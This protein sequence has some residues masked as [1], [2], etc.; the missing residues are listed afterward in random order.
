MIKVYILDTE[1]TGIGKTD[2]VI[3]V[4]YNKLSSLE[5]E[6]DIF[7]SSS[8]ANYKEYFLQD[9]VTERFFPS[10]PINEFAFN[11]HGIRRAEL[12]GERHS[13][14][15]DIPEVD[16]LIGQNIPFDVKML[17]QSNSAIKDRLSTIKLIDAI[18]LARAL[19]KHQSLGLEAFNLDYLVKTFFPED[20]ELLFSKYHSSSLDIL[21]TMVVLFKLITP[22]ENVRTWE[23]LSKLQ[24]TLK[25]V[26]KK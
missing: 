3:E 1:T 4:S 12:A 5:E 26:K 17:G 22:L 18:P 2:D 25:G 24:T 6:L 21:R 14:F 16:Y 8:I 19:N 23:E 15:V 10:M 13:K 11:C 7:K 20:K 9:V